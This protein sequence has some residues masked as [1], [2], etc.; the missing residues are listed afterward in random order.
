MEQHTD[1]ELLESLVRDVKAM[2]A[3]FNK[4]EDGGLAYSEHKLF[5][6]TQHNKIVDIRDRNNKVFS[7]IVT[8]TLIGGI[9]L[10]INYLLPIFNQVLSSTGGK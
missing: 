1:R 4:D 5:H 8:W 7:N 10:I 9:T 2:Q 6:K 3:A